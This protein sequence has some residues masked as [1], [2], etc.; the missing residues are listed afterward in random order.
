MNGGEKEDGKEDKEGKKAEEEGAEESASLKV[1]EDDRKTWRVV[2]LMRDI[3][4][5]MAD[6]D[7]RSEGAGCAAPRVSYSL[8]SRI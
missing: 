4:V 8:W 5:N 1:D 7:F 3:F 2:R 6:K